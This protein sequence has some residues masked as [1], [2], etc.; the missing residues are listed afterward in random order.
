MTSD[1]DRCFYEH[2]MARS[3]DVTESW[4]CNTLRKDHS[5]PVDDHP[6]TG[7]AHDAGLRELV[8]T[9][10]ELIEMIKPSEPNSF[11]QGFIEGLEHAEAALSAQPAEPV[12]DGN[13][14]SPNCQHKIE[15]A[16]S[17]DQL[18]TCVR[19]MNSYHEG[20]THNENSDC[21]RPSKFAPAGGSDA[22]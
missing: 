18:V 12:C 17:V 7:P 4:P 14:H 2:T 9:R 11:Q 3:K 16:I 10:T 20:V 5:E 8:K 21:I 22:D 6:F 19:S 13:T 15:F 1:Y